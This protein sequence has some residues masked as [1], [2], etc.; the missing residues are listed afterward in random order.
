MGSL[1]FAHRLQ[2]R[3]HQEAPGSMKIKTRG[4]R[5]RVPMWAG[6]GR[7]LSGTER[8]LC[9]QATSCWTPTWPLC[10]LCDL[11]PSHC[12]VSASVSSVCD[13]SNGSSGSEVAG[14]R[15]EG[16]GP[17]TGATTQD[18][19]LQPGTG[20]GPTS[21]VSLP[22][23]HGPTCESLVPRPKDHTCTHCSCR[24]FIHWGFGSMV[25]Q[26]TSSQV[27]SAGSPTP[28]PGNPGVLILLQ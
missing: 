13:G 4:E 16:K 7:N 2:L 1:I 14:S 8:R 25:P 18:L 10:L 23:H 3:K 26:A 27:A 28:H 22:V 21:N 20:M 6:E 17:S 9:S 24:S 19:L 12:A 5:Q 15:A 11:W